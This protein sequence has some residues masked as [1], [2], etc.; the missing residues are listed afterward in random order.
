MPDIKVVDCPNCNAPSNIAGQKCHNCGILID[1]EG[2]QSGPAPL[3]VAATPGETYSTPE[4]SRALMTV[5]GVYYVLG[6]LAFIGLLVREEVVFAFSILFVAIAS[7]AIIWGMARAID[8][9][10]KIHLRLEK[11]AT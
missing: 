11:N 6:I 10:N 3:R 4:I 7:G 8:L 9:L 5:G 2:M 1:S